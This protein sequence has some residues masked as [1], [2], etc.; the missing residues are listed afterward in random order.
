MTLSSATAQ[1]PTFVAPTNGPVTLHFQL[2]VTDPL[3]AASPADSVDIAVNANALPTANAGPNQTGIAPNAPVTLDGSGST[4][5]EGFTITYAWT[6]VDGAGVPITPTVTL[7]SA[8]AQKP[9]F[10]A[11]N[12]PFGSTLR[13]SL[14]VTD[15]F[16]AV[17]RAG[18]RADQRGHQPA[19]RRQRGPRPDAG[20]RQGRDPRRLGIRPTPRA[21]RS[22]TSGSRR[23]RAAARSCPATRCR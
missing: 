10:T 11:P 7:S 12:T 19:A 6:Q 4:D 15:Q 9:T 8:T 3:G 13:F 17:E 20:P 1:K 16:G 23:T 2:V 18:L 5:P 14:V 21:P 22:P